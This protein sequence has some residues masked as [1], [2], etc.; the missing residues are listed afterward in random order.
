LL[1]GN[2]ELQTRGLQDF[3]INQKI[4]IVVKC[5]DWGEWFWEK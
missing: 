3:I 4:A 1:G 2:D 5:I